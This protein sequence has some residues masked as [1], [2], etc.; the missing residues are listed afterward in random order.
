MVTL[1]AWAR[2]G[3]RNAE[4][5]DG[6]VPRMSSDPAY[7]PAAQLEANVPCALEIARIDPIAQASLPEMR[8]RT[9]P[10][11]AM[12]AMIPMIATTMSSSISV[13][14]AVRRNFMTE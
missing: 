14:P 12:A 10:G 1:G 11:M 6:P 8:A 3:L 7:L 2:S 13:N 9:R 4:P 5:P